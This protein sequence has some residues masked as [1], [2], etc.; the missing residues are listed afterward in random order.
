LCQTHP[1]S[2]DGRKAPEVLFERDSLYIWNVPITNGDLRYVI[3][4]NDKVFVEVTDL[5]GKEKKKWQSRLGSQNIPK[6][7]ASL[8]YIGGGRPKQGKISA[9]VA[10][11]NNLGPWLK[12]RG[13]DA[14]MFESLLAGELMPKAS[15]E[16]IFS[17]AYP[18]A[19]GHRSEASPFSNPAKAAGAAAA[20]AAG[21]L[22]YA[23]QQQA[24]T[25]TAAAAGSRVSNGSPL[26]GSSSSCNSSFQAAV[27]NKALKLTQKTMSLQTPEDPEVRLLIQDDSEAQLALFLSKTLTNAIMM[28]RQVLI[29]CKFFLMVFLI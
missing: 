14:R 20:S 19:A 18:S 13:L 23:Q 3:N 11:N 4:E 2:K 7:I 15:E 9:R 8:V 26:A 28:Y 22:N 12:K 10:D 21:N 29:D 16:D 25:T 1:N 5:L 6:F 17:Q 24:P 27:L